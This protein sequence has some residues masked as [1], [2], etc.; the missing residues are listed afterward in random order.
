M[1]VTLNIE[2][3]EELRASIKNAID[4]QIRSIIRSEVNAIVIE[5]LSRILK[6]SLTVSLDKKINYFLDKAV[7]KM[8]EE[9]MTKDPNFSVQN[10]VQRLNNE[11]D[12]AV[13]GNDWNQIVNTI[14]KEKIAEL[15]SKV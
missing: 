14:A 13:S 4:G 7:T 9:K 3:D 10:I 8:A 6:G 1:Q 2:K 5:E 12:K 11:I 15:A